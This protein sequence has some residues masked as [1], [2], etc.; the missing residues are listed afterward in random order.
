MGRWTGGLNKTQSCENTN[1]NFMIIENDADHE[2]EV[3]E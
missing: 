1:C 3:V 2:K